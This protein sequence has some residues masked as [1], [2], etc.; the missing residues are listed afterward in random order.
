MYASFFIDAVAVVGVVSLLQRVAAQSWGNVTSC[1]NWTDGTPPEGTFFAITHGENAKLYT[2]DIPEMEFTFVAQLNHRFSSIAWN[3]SGTF[4]Y[5][6]TTV[7]GSNPCEN[8]LVK[9]DPC[10]CWAETILVQDLADGG[11]IPTIAFVSDTFIYAVS[12]I[13]SQDFLLS[14]DLT[15]ESNVTVAHL[16]ECDDGTSTP[17]VNVHPDGLI[18]TQGGTGNAYDLNPTTENTTLKGRL[19]LCGFPQPNSEKRM[20]R[21][22]GYVSGQQLVGI[23]HNHPSDPI[24]VVADYSDLNSPFVVNTYGPL[25]ET[26]KYIAAFSSE[27]STHCWET[28][29]CTTTTSSGAASDSTTDSSTTTS[30]TEV[31]DTSQAALVSWSAWLL[32]SGWCVH[33]W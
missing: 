21:G 4:L 19:D 32:L 22:N 12:V 16:Y 10:N 3:P 20:C 33:V 13:D 11:T 29:V 25:P 31:Q 27:S 28:T 6:T 14:V 2:F 24:I 7:H 17:S 15:D 23:A 30:S 26:F 9:L 18:Y 1:S 5:G 8:C